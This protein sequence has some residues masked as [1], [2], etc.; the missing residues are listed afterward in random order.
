MS[1]ITN[2]TIRILVIFLL[3]CA[4]KTDYPSYKDQ[5]NKGEKV[6]LRDIQTCEGFSNENTKQIE[7]SKGAGER[8]N[9]KNSIF[10]LCMKNKHWV[11]R[12][13]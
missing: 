8:M 13:E 7:G 9:H 12:S 3:G 2:L 5:K 4:P 11:L 1:R 10:L 6:F